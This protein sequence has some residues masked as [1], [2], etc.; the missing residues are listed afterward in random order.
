MGATAVE[1]VEKI[2][3]TVSE[4]IRSLSWHYRNRKKMLKTLLM[5]LKHYIRNDK[6]YCLLMSEM[7]DGMKVI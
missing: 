1:L 3:L 4:S 2:S 7:L 5:R 6:I